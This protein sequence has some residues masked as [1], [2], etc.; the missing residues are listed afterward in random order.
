M[1]N[2]LK[3]AAAVAFVVVPMQAS[4]VTAD[5][6]FNGTVTHTC[7]INVTGGG[8]M[9]ADAGFQNLSSLGAGGNA[10]TAEVVATGNGFD[11]SIDV[12]TAFSSEP[13]AD[14]TGET[15]AA[16]YTTTGATSVTGSATGGNNSGAEN[17]NNGTTNVAV[18]LTAS[19][20]GADVFEAGAYDAVVVL[21]CE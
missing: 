18:D 10:G 21:R 6:P 19:K 7:T 13:A 20:A 3:V 16:S 4:A 5:I 8:I 14:L 2:L 1:K 11:V 9:V 15:F 17:L 12:P